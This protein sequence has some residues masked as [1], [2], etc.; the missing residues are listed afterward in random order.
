M[1]NIEADVSEEAVTT[2]TAR[3]GRCNT[4]LKQWDDDYTAM[5]EIKCECCGSVNEI[6]VA[7]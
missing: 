1:D 5:F 6:S 2:Y 3:C 7:Y 4:E